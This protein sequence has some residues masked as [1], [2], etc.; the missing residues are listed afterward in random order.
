MKLEERIEYLEMKKRHKKVLRP[1][2]KKWWGV[3]LLSL[4]VIILISVISFAFLINRLIKNPMEMAMVL[5][6]DYL[7]EMEGLS[8]SNESRMTLVEGPAL[9]YL[10]TSDPLVTITVFLDFSCPYCKQS[11]Q[12]ISQLVSEYKDEIKI[13]VRDFPVISEGSIELALAAR[14]AGEQGRYWNMF[15]QLF[16][17]QGNFSSSEL[18]SLAR[19]AGV[20]DL[21]KFSQCLSSEKY[22]KDIAKDFSDAQFLGVSATPAWFADGYSIGEGAI[23][24]EDWSI[25]LIEIMKSKLVETEGLDTE[26]LD[27]NNI[28]TE[29]LNKENINSENVNVEN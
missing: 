17:K 12:V 8:M 18:S 27:I 14:C 1:W 2:Y 5:N 23:P 13:I 10:G 22:K 20:P 21:D 16:D 9:Y 6:P 7:T 28:D 29:N 19:L 4:A 11:S 26:N 3:L 15:Y 25:F 24:F